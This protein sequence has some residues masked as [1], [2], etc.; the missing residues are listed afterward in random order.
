MTEEEKIEKEF[1]E[2][3]LTVEMGQ[4]YNARTGFFAGR[5]RGQ[6]EMDKLKKE[7]DL[8]RDRLTPK[9]GFSRIV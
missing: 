7:N 3:R 5:R 1:E 4:P 9:P 2:W 6:E 8:L